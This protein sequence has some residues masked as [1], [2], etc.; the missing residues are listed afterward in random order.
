[1]FFNIEKHF[2]LHPKSTIKLNAKQVKENIFNGISRIN[3][4]WH[5]RSSRSYLE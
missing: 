3:Q 5:D 4:Q 2:N 1:M